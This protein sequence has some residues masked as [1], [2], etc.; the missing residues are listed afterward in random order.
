MK[1]KLKIGLA[2]ASSLLLLAACGNS[3]NG[4]YV[5]NP[6]LPLSTD[7]T[8]EITINGDK[9]TMVIEV[10]GL[11]MIAS[12]TTADIIVDQKEKVITVDDGTKLTYELV[13][14]SLKIISDSTEI[15]TGEVF[16]RKAKE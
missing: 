15:F 11:G 2:L 4:T 14:G 1:K 10:K 13:D 12:T 3:V 8:V 9:G 7:E 5:G 6:D 16:K